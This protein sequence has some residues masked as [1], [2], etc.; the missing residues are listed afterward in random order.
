[1]AQTVQ[2]K[3]TDTM[4]RTQMERCPD[5]PSSQQ[6]GGGRRADGRSVSH[7]KCRWKL[8]SSTFPLLP[9]VSMSLPPSVSVST[10]LYHSP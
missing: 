9:P 10:H 4:I 7:L 2:T 6:T 8:L 3:A 5:V 1:M